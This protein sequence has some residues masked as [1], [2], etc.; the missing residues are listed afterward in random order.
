MKSTHRVIV[1]AVLFLSVTK[2]L[3]AMN[4]ADPHADKILPFDERAKAVNRPLCNLFV[5]M[6]QNMGIETDRF[7]SNAGTLNELRPA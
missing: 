5:T 7:G 3:A 2:L 6:L 1:I 4:G